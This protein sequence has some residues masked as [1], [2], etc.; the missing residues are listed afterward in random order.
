MASFE[1]VAPAQT[2]V[3]LTTLHSFGAS[4][5]AGGDSLDGSNPQAALLQG[6]DGNFYGTTAFG[7]PGA[8][9]GGTVFRMAS[10]GTL[11]ILQSL[12]SVGNS[13]TLPLAGLTQ[14]R[15]GNLYGTTSSGGVN[16]IGTIFKIATNG[17]LTTL[18]SFGSVQ[19][20]SGTRLMAGGPKA[21]W[22][23]AATA[24]STVPQQWGGTLAVIFS[25]ALAPYLK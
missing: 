4:Q 9:I 10:D 1:T 5:D 17:V 18:Y 13:G 22:S 20:A 6:S 14:D 21:G 7:G 23:R 3:M 25:S 2:K 8:I 24:V 12:E 16:D 15:A 19:D 11:T